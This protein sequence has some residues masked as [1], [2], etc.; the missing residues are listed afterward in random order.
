MGS[1]EVPKVIG[2]ATERSGLT[3]IEML[4]V[5]TVLALTA[6]ALLPNQRSRGT[7]TPEEVIA[8]LGDTLRRWQMQSS[9]TVLCTA[10]KVTLSPMVP[11]ASSTMS[12]T[13]RL[14]PGWNFTWQNRNDEEITSF[15]VPARSEIFFSETAAHT[16]EEIRI[17]LEHDLHVGADSKYTWLW[18][19]LSGQITPHQAISDFPPEE[20]E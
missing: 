1:G 5:I 11:Q 15:N 12:A 4:A 19:P 9:G 13:W 20:R 17:S 2:K 6:A 7:Q 18:L 8:Q 10:N 14:P 16:F 3:L